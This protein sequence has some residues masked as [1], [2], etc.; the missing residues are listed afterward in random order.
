MK[1]LFSLLAI[2]GIILASNCSRIPENNDPIIGYW[3]KVEVMTADQ[4]GKQTILQ[5]W[6]FNDAYLGRYNHEVNYKETIRT[7]FKWSEED[8]VYTISYPGTDLPNQIVSREETEE[9]EILKDAQGA[10]IA[11]RQ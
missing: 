9:G 1:K 5:K 11:I 2:I 3:E 8:G 7:D 10:T 4:A 6:T